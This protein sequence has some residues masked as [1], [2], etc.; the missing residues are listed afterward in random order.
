[1]PKTPHWFLAGAALAALAAAGP[2]SAHPHEAHGKDE[3]RAERHVHIT[4]VG[5]GDVVIRRGD[6]TEHLKDVLQLRPDQEPALKAFLEATRREHARHEM[7]RFEHDSGKTTLERLSEMEAKMAEQH[8]AMKARIDA[9]RAFYAQLD[10]KQRKAF[11][12]MPMLMMVGPGL[13]PMMIPH[14]A[15]LDAPPKPPRPPMPPKPP[16]P[17]EPPPPPM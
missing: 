17:P 11:D 10:A 5:D 12:A 3:A 2:A 6:R 14:M 16:G 7:V 8:K 9:T 13:G 4:R 1:M 15:H